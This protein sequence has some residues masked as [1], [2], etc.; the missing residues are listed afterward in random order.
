MV[1]P[2]A[3]F[4][5]VKVSSRSDRPLP[6]P[7]IDGLG[8]EITIALFSDSGEPQGVARMR[9]IIQSDDEWQKQLTS[10]EFAVTRR[11]GTERPY[12]GRTWN[13]HRAGVY[14][15]IGCGTAL[16]RST[17]KF[18]SGTGWPSF[19]APIAGGNVALSKDV[20]LFLERTEVRCAKCDAHLGHV[21]DD[22]PA[23]AGKRFCMNSAAMRFVAAS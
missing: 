5:L 6:E 1:M 21:F 10:A 23:P 18:D 17:E 16:F 13:E 8:S 3:L 19:R 22:G 2:F 11:G 12:T 7:A 4:G 15:C 9:R 14:R 20:S